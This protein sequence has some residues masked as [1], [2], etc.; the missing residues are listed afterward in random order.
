MKIAIFFTYDYSIETLSRSGL[1]ERELKVYQKINEIYGIEFIFLTYEESLGEDINSYSEFKFIPLYKD[2]KK[3][4]NKLL[5]FFK[6][7]FIPFKI[8]SDLLDVDILY[9][10][11]LLGVWIPLI[12]KMKLKKPLQVRTGYDAYLFSLKNRDNFVKSLFYKYLKKIALRFADLYTVTS[13][14]DKVFLSEKFKSNSIKVVPNWVEINDNQPTS[15]EMCKILM[16][17]RLEKQK[18]YPLAFDFLKTLNSNYELDIYGNGS[19]YSSLKTL[20]SEN[21]LKINFLGNTTHQNLIRE[22]SNYNFFLTTSF[23]EGNPKSVLEA[24]SS[25]CIIFASNIPNHE[26][27][28]KDGIN[29][30]LFSNKEELVDKFEFIKNNLSQQRKVKKNCISSLSENQIKN[31]SKLMYEDYVFLVSLR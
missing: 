10:H 20:S 17:G 11:Q 13:H 12:L 5:R 4:N 21:N 19:E 24:L 18:N 15:R 3:S 2:L 7:F 16:V 6:S 14:C 23:Y 8:K 25:Q 1:L 31:I 26:E 29:G 27:L 9:Q 30:F 28:I 22:F